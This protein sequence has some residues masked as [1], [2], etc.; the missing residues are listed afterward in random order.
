MVRASSSPHTFFRTARIL[1]RMTIVSSLKNTQ[2]PYGVLHVKEDGIITEIEEKPSKTKYEPIT[3]ELKVGDDVYV[4]DYDQHG[5]ISKI[6]KDGTYL[7]S[8]GNVN[9][10][11]DIEDLALS[12]ETSKKTILHLI[13]Y[14]I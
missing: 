1:L 13:Y 4:K 5:V 14:I 7:V 8:F 2:L 6:M 9:M 11:L 3:K 12:K 10:R